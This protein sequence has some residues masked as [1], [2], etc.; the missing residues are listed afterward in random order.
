MTLQELADYLGVASTSSLR[1]QIRR[2]ALQ[3]TRVGA[4][5][6]LVSAEEARR[7]KEENRAGEGRRGRPSRREDAK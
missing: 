4:R 2:G 7:Y 5:T 3:A 6:W 1:A